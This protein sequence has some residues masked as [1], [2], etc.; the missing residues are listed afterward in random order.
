MATRQQ[1]IT[2]THNHPTVLQLNQTFNTNP[3]LAGYVGTLGTRHIQAGDLK[4]RDERGRKESERKCFLS[5]KLIEYHLLWMC[6]QASEIKASSV[7]DMPTHSYVCV[8]VCML[9]GC[10]RAQDIIWHVCASLFMC[11]CVYAC[12][13]MCVIL[14]SRCL[15]APQQTVSS[16]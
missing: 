16:L 7:L 8:C 4:A 3:N 9:W 11:V 6:E 10:K 5:N 2:A 14:V 15:S 13:C 1:N 12:A